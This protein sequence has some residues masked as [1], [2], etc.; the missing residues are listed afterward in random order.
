[1]LELDAEALRALRWREAAIV[2]QS[3]LD[4]LDPVMRVDEQVAEAVLAHRAVPRREALSL[5]REQ[6]ARVRIPEARFGAFPHQL[7]GG[8]RQRVVIAMALAL[9]PKL[10][11]MD[12]P[13][14]AL[15]VV[16]QQEILAELVAL[17]RELGFS[18]LFVSHDL[19]LMLDL[20]HR[21]GVLYA[22]RLVEVAE[23]AELRRGAQH[24]YTRGLMSS[25]PSLDGPRSALEGIGGAPPSLAR[26]PPG[27]RFH[28]RCP[29][30]FA[31]CDAR[32]PEVTRVGP[33]HAVACHLFADEVPGASRAP[34]DGPGG[35][36]R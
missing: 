3:A 25:F 7:S 6:L 21:I 28:P 35:G 30:A 9:A 20:C 18:V 36:V 12:E 31:P 1:V 19:P 2:F 4:A 33:R 22:G 5:A 32:T 26:L 34:G 11:V 8:M 10:L 14:T 24:P 16:V 27:C 13:T 29:R 23:S 17:Q 15:D